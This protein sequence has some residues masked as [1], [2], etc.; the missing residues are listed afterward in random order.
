V[1]IEGGKIIK[2]DSASCNEGTDLCIRALFFNTPARRKFLKSQETEEAKVRQWIIQSA[3]PNFTVRYRLFTNGKEILNLPKVA[4]LIERSRAFI[5]GSFSEFSH[6]QRDIL[7]SGIVGHPGSASTL[8]SSLVIVVNGR[9]VKDNIILRAVREGFSSTLK[10]YESPVGL[11][12]IEL[13][14]SQVD[15]NV[16]PQKSEVRFLSSGEI[17]VAVRDGVAQAV[18]GFIS[19][20]YVKE[21]EETYQS[22][23]SISSTSNISHSQEAI[24]FVSKNLKASPIRFEAVSSFDYKSKI[25][26]AQIF[27]ESTF[28][29]SSLKY[30][31]Q[32][33]DCFLLCEGDGQLCVVDM[34]A[35]HERVNY[36]R[37]REG[38]KTAS[39]PEQRLLMPLVVAMPQDAVINI[40][41][42]AEGLSRWG[43][44]VERFGR[45]E[46]A[47]R[48]APSIMKISA[49]PDLLKEIGSLSL[50]NMTDGAISEKIDHI[51]ARIACHT[52]IRSG[53][54]MNKE[55]AYSLFSA[56]DETELSGVCPHGRPVVVEFSKAQV[57]RWFGRDK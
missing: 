35:A 3:I 56:M 24:N 43:F 31:G 50:S 6:K 41:E 19:P 11:I 12:S 8:S 57:E 36:N 7:I 13:P 16:H 40:V 2:V 48:S 54:I 52:S 29:Y 25:E 14:Y 10:S 51:A 44:E 22:N 30:V 33:F 9:V 47:V 39:V 32:I 4:S 53:K 15:V 5:K 37:I 42:N 49:I 17:F 1:Q 55:E 23:L 28:K 38:F 27:Q 46:I 21:K 20:I 26:P 18:K 34:H 45:E